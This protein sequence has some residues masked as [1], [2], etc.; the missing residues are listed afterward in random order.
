[1]GL[2][3]NSTFGDFLWSRLRLF[4]NCKVFEMLNRSVPKYIHVLFIT[5]R[6]LRKGN[7]FTS[8]RQEFCPGGCVSQHALGQT[9][10]CPVHAGIHPPG[11]HPP[12]TDTPRTDTPPRQ[13]VQ[14]T[15]RM[16]L[17]CILFEMMCDY[18]CLLHH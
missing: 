12:W 5:V 11:R 10:P 15:V 17:E 14:Q 13:P 18:P 3:F 7:V 9:P 4:I 16:L 8:M 2:K 6:K 1:M